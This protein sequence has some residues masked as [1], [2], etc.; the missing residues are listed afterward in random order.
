MKIKN[1]FNLKNKNLLFSTA[2]TALAIIISLLIAIFIIFAV[3]A[4]PGN[5]IS[6][7][8]LGP[9]QSKRLIGSIFTTAIPICFTGLAVCIMFQAS[10]F[11][12]CA[13]GSFFLGAIG[14][15]AVATKLPL[16]GILGV[17]APFVIGGVAGGLLCYIPAVLKAKWGASEMVSSLMLNY[18]ALYLGLYLLN[19]FLRDP[20]FGALASDQLPQ[21]SRLGKLIPGTSIHAG[22]IVVIV[23]IV[24]CYLLIYK[25]ALGHKIRT[26]GQNKKFAEYTGVKVGSVIILSQVIGGAIAGIGGSVEIMGMY[27]RFQWTSLPGYGWD[28]VILA[29]LARNKPQFIPIAALFLSYLRV[30]ASTMASN[31][32]V[33]KELIVVIQSIMIMLATAGAL[34]KGVKQKAVIK[35][36]LANGSN[37]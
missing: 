5:A 32:D 6:A 35:E 18:I 12:M 4:Q 7:L 9:L 2:T 23:F 19:T 27:A 17:A 37:S 36:V 21:N 31:T 14:A 13:E 24:L 33:P 10:M 11:N 15:A 28:G 25:T 8:L 22:I 29:I 30:G 16:P 1:M 26:L 3:S 34:L 20:S